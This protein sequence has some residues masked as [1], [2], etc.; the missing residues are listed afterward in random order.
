MHYDEL[1]L[2]L[3]HKRKTKHKIG[4]NRIN[5]NAELKNPNRTEFKNRHM[6]LK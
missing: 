6:Y 4:L 2:A 1:K 5:L 3:T